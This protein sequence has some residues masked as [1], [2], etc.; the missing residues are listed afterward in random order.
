MQNSTR[1]IRR[2]CSRKARLEPCGPGV[3]MAPAMHLDDLLSSSLYKA[4]VARPGGL[5]TKGTARA[6][7]SWSWNVSCHAWTTSRAT[8]HTKHDWQDQ[9]VLQP[10]A[11]LEPCGPKPCG[12]KPCGPKPCG[13]KPC[14]PKPC[15]IEAMRSSSCRHCPG[16]CKQPRPRVEGE[17]PRGSPHN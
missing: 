15:G 2:S 10:K 5:A 4:R 8:D 1:K 12:P 9:E 3:G 16:T 13:P 14:G 6:V 17:L 11:R 7:R